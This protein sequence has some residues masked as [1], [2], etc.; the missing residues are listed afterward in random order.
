M[1]FKKLFLK[2]PLDMI[3]LLFQIVANIAL[4]IHCHLLPAIASIDLHIQATPSKAAV[5]IS[6]YLSKA[7]GS[8]IMHKIMRT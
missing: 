2:S 7:V 5:Q 3:S 1:L 6:L 4:H 8:I